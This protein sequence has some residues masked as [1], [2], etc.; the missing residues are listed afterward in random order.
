MRSP[1][2]QLPLQVFIDAWKGRS[3]THSRDNYIWGTVVFLPMFIVVAIMFCG[4]ESTTCTQQGERSH[5]AMIHQHC[6]N[7]LQEVEL[8]WYGSIVNDILMRLVE[9]FTSL[10]SLLIHNEVS[11]EVWLQ[12]ITHSRCNLQKLDLCVLH[13]LKDNH[14]LAVAEKFRGLSSLRLHSCFLVTPE[15]LKTMVLAMSNKLEELAMLNCKVEP[16]LLT[17]LGQSVIYLRKLDLSFNNNAADK[18]FIT[19]LALCNCLREVKVRGCKGLNNASVVSM[20]KSC[21]LESVD[22]MYCCWIDIEA[23]ELLVWNCLRLRKIQV[24]ESKLSEVSRSWALNKLVEVV[25]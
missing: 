12:F 21:K 6:F 15:G 22:I 19:M 17:T 13:D 10:N 20:F 11:K 23:V 16:G 4:L 1:T 18:K 8:R 9:N 7:G 14:L 24:E 3:F 5:S 2:P 25:L